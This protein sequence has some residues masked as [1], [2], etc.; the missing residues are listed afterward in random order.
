MGKV[1][2]LLF[3]SLLI[4]SCGRSENSVAGVYVKSPSVNTIDTLILYVDTLYPSVVPGRKV[5]RYKQRFYNKKTGALLFENTNKWWLRN[6][7]RVE[8]GG[9]YMD[10]DNPPVV[11]SFSK[12]RLENAVIQSSLPIK[13][14]SLAVDFDRGVRYQKIK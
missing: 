5:Y 13:G 3:I 1:F 11:D 8:F 14:S 6:N 2:I 7:N 4:F 9:F 12:Q 10:G